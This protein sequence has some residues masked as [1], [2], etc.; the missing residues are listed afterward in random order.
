M[1]DFYYTIA[2]PKMTTEPEDVT[3]RSHLVCYKGVNLYVRPY[4]AHHYQITGLCTTNPAHYLNRELAPG[5]LIPL[6]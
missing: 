3:T 4:D 5:A 6:F 2:P 1:D